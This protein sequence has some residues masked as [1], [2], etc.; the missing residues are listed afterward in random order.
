MSRIRSRS[1]VTLLLTA[2]LL[3]SQTAASSQV[4]TDSLEKQLAK[5]RKSGNKQD[6]SRVLYDLGVK[7]LERGDSKTAEALVRQSLEIDNS[8]PDAQTKSKKDNQEFYP[9]VHTRCALAQILAAQGRFDEAL[10]L[11][12]EAADRANKMGLASEAAK[13]TKQVGSVYIALNQR[14]KAAETFNRAIEMAKQADNHECEVACLTELAVLSRQQQKLDEALGYLKKAAQVAEDTLDNVA[15]GR[16]LDEFGRTYSDMNLSEQALEYYQKAAKEYEAGGELELLAR[17]LVSMGEV[18]LKDRKPQEAIPYLLK[19]Q[20]QVSEDTDA[21]T[22]ARIMNALG[23][24]KADTGAFDEARQLHKNAEKVADRGKNYSEELTAITEQGY[25]F[26]LQGSSEKALRE[27]LRAQKFGDKYPFPAARRAELLEHVGMG[28]RSV[29]QMRA[30]IKCYLEA[31]RLYGEAKK[32]LEQA[33]NLDSVAA[34]YL[35]QGDMDQFQKYHDAAKSTFGSIAGGAGESAKTATTNV[36]KRV[37]AAISYNYGQYC[38]FKNQYADAIPA[39]EQSLEAYKSCGDTLG[40]CQALRGLGLTYL[41]LGQAGKSREY[42][43]AASTLADKLGNIESQWDCATGLGKAY[44]ELGDTTHAEQMLRKAVALADQER[45]RLSRDSFKTA[46]L[47][48]REDCFLD[49]ISVLIQSKRY[50]QALEIAEK[51]RARAFLD[52]LEGR[53][54]S[55]ITQKRL[56]S[57]APNDLTAEV[58]ES[59]EAQSKPVQIAMATVPNAGF[60]SVSVTPKTTNV[61]EASVI[62]PTNAKP[63][64]LA[65]IKALVKGCNTYLVE[66]LTM[67]DKVVIWVLKPDGEVADVVTVKVKLSDLK[68]QIRDTYASIT[69]QPKGMEELHALNKKRQD[70]LQALYKTLVEPIEP[71]LPKDENAVVTIVPHQALFNVPFSALISGK[72]RFFIEDPTLAYLPA[73]GVLRATNEIDAEVQ[74]QKNSLLA[75]GNPITEANKFLGKLPYAEKE[76]KK[77][78]SLFGQG[79][80]DVEVGAT[81]TKAKFRDLAPKYGFIHLATHG[82]INQD[83]PMDSAVVLAPEGDDDGLL[84]VKDILQLPALKSK[85]IVLSA[86]QTGKGKVTGDGVVGLSR[87]FMIAGTTSVMVSLWSVDDV[88]TEYQMES[89]YY[90]LLHGANKAGALRKAQLKTINFME[91]GLPSS[92]SDESSK[93][94]AGTAGGIRANPRYWAAFQLIGEYK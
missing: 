23:A 49:L 52:M 60:R 12:Q 83:Q 87:A 64:T 28:Y 6:E 94:A 40:H 13:I 8:L 77:V 84:T 11:L 10:P 51:G 19:A 2:C 53:R 14:E 82:L 17:V 73:I 80:T 36:N 44:L 37:Q 32:P 18:E 54:Q 31:A 48:L 56:A 42:F 20:K 72:G 86:C 39:F 88:M 16:V 43:E 4:D 93:A 46:A 59:D 85:M 58:I 26:L 57:V 9:P 67:P 74:S 33:L 35:D 41:L 45:N 25:D 61:I 50:D 62:S 70:N 55:S 76:V 68:D 63:P 71:L 91:K 27:F 79:D 24:A 78:A 66:Y 15:V 7:A 65:E 90:E 21:K 38:V 3:F 34:A 47:D 5:A 69:T 30:A 92:R 81:A 1:A 75:F 29:A 22:L 89:L